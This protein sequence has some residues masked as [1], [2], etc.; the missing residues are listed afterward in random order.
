MAMT[1]QQADAIYTLLIKEC[2]A[3]EQRRGIFNSTYINQT[4]D[5]TWYF[6]SRLGPYGKFLYDDTDTEP[7]AMVFADWLTPVTKQI[8]NS[9]NI[10]LKEILQNKDLQQEDKLSNKIFSSIKIGLVYISMIPGDIVIYLRKIFRRK[11]KKYE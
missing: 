2:D 3:P 9:V 11:N 8:R 5:R 7:Y 4:G 6:N 1:K 10:S